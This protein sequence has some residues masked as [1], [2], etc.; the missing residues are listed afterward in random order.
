MTPDAFTLFCQELCLAIARDK[1]TPPWFF[2]L[3]CQRLG[4]PTLKNFQNS[5]V[6]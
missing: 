1:D 4:L 3:L 6:L 2:E 5:E